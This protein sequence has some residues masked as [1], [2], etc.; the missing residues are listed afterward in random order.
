MN[1]AQLT[2]QNAATSLSK[3]QDA[4]EQSTSTRIESL[5]AQ[6]TSLLDHL[7][8]PYSPPSSPLN[9]SSPTQLSVQTSSPT[10]TTDQQV[11]PIPSPPLCQSTHS[12][13]LSSSRESSMSPVLLAASRTLGFTPIPKDN[14]LQTP[15]TI[16]SLITS[17]LHNK[18]SIPMNIIQAMN[19]N[20]IFRLKDSLTVF[21][22]FQTGRDVSNVFKHVNFLPKDCSIRRYILPS[23]E[24]KYSYLSETA[25][26]IR[27]QES[28]HQTKIVY[29]SDSL[30]LYTRK[31]GETIWHSHQA[32]LV[33]DPNPQ[34]ASSPNRVINSP[35]S[36]EDAMMKVPSVSL[37]PLQ[38]H[39]LSPMPKPLTP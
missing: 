2:I 7:R 37:Q 39:H 18:L 32:S 10:I 4:L 36:S 19:H 29:E 21:V 27:N 38:L 1:S 16:Q 26:K 15:T 17:F 22:E 6:I 3:R 14:G 35:G 28:K 30:A 8:H 13:L 20:K 25:A 12:P 9:S 23:L 11:I 31:V 24:E 33:P 5:H 34:A